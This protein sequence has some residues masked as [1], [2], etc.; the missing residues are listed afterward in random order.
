MVKYKTAQALACWH[1]I[2]IKN[3]PLCLKP[4]STGKSI[5]ETRQKIFLG[6]LKKMMLKKIKK[7]TPLNAL[8]VERKLELLG[9]IKHC[10]MGMRHFSS[11]WSLEGLIKRKVLPW[12]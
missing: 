8:D 2:T 4:F 6:Y 7:L 11:G 9:A 3:S 5:G 10:C 1:P 12:Q